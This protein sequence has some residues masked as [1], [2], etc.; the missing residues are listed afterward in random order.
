MTI[1][2]SSE[3]VRLLR[4]RA[5]RL[6]PQQRGSH[7]G[8]ANLVK[9]LCGIQAQD[10]HAAPLALRVRSNGLIATDVEQARTKERTIVRTW[11][12]RYTLH[13]IASEDLAWL[14]PLFGPVF[15]ANSQRRRSELGLDEETYRRA[16][17]VLRDVLAQQGPL[18]RD[19]IVEQL[20]MHNL[21]LEGQAR[22][23]LLGRAALEGLLCLG[24]NRGAEPTYVLLNDWIDLPKQTLSQEA[25]LSKLTHRYLNAHGPATPEDMAAWS[26][27]PLSRIRAAWQQLAD[28]LIE[29]NIVGSLSSTAW[30]L[31]THRAWLDEPPVPTPII[32]LLPSFDIYLLGYRD[33]SLMVP[34]QHAKRINAGGGILHPTLLVN[35]QVVGTWKSQRKK[36]KM[37]V[38]IEAFDQLAPEVY[39]GLEAEI[40]D[41]G[42][43]LAMQ[44]SVQFK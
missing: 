6:I 1:S 38:L 24:P 16:I 37:D 25:A 13:L 23:H 35:G 33:R 3:Q 30:M 4:L 36:N 40:I 19:E 10:I 15:I 41:L 2:L 8:V 18:T 44:T 9:E 20:A 27:L 43:F 29:V 21:H 7:S 26:G 12:A 34:Q 39:P 5:Q 11:G 17:S 14:L 28:Q 32:S 31:R 22:P 42:R